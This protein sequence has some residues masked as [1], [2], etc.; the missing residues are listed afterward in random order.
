MSNILIQLLLS[1][2]VVFFDERL[3]KKVLNLLLQVTFLIFI[4][5]ISLVFYTNT[6]ESQNINLENDNFYD[7]G[8][9]KTC[10]FSINS[11]TSVF[12]TQSTYSEYGLKRDSISLFPEFGNFKCF[13]KI[14]RYETD[15]KSI[16]IFVGTSSR[17]LTLFNIL[18]GV[19]FFF[20]LFNSKHNL[21]NFVYAFLYILFDYLLN[22]Y[23]FNSS[24][25]Y[26]FLITKLIT[27]Y[28]IYEI[29]I[30]KRKLNKLLQNILIFIILYISTQ[31]FNM[32]LTPDDLYYLGYSLRGN[33]PYT[34]F[35]GNNQWFLYAS[36]IK[37]LYIV[38]GL[39]LKIFLEL[40]L[41][42]WLTGLIYFYSKH[43]KL[44][45]Q[46][47]LL[48]PV[49]ITMNQ[50]F[51]AGDQ[52]W[53]SPVPKAFFYLATLT[54]IYLLLNGKIFYANL[55]FTIA[56]YL[57]L[58][59][60]VVWLPFIAYIHLKYR[61][62]DEIVKSA[63]GVFLLSS[64]LLYFLIT[65]NF[66]NQGSENLRYDNLE[67]IIKFYMPFHVY[68]FSY[69][70]S[71]ILKINPSWYGNFRNIAIFIITVA[72]YS[73]FYNKKKTQLFSAIQFTTCVLIFYLM[74]NYISPINTFIL[75]QPYKIIS[76]LVILSVIFILKELEKLPEDSR[77]LTY[78][79][80]FIFISFS[81]FNYSL[82]E[83]GYKDTR[84][85]TSN[86]EIREKII[87]ISPEVL[88]LPLYFQGS[89][90][91]E[92]HDLEIRTEIDTYVTYHYFPQSISAIS[93]WQDR[94][95]NLEE[96]Y[97]GRCE[98]FNFIDNYIF[99]DYSENNKCGVIIEKVG[100]IF[101][102]KVKK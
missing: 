45:Q 10:E 80:I 52:F 48:F 72:I 19:V 74:V 76:L 86:E 102:Y 15:D 4:L 18:F 37:F 87:E 81:M 62:F 100:D 6:S 26:E 12:E 93:E 13:G 67:Y 99:L 22:I 69:D 51:A 59:A 98:T 96:F 36:L 101:I 91:S 88:L 46:T 84:N 32:N 73:I 42:V 92:F 56:I 65:E 55:F 29:V 89:V 47:Y 41:C 94:I 90:Q 63:I 57:H 17:L 2:L 28:L 38:F 70:A 14:T 33:T 71:N 54:A 53:G 25:N 16:L 5:L 30:K 77:F 43:F 68:P 95:L 34:S 24:L 3:S 82:S 60:F 35:F 8:N 40:L 31:P 21:F 11:F 78:L 66:I 23:I 50:S 1:K 7:I 20:L 49:L 85:F 83:I 27:M 58:A 61:K 44:S 97:L 64:P 75:L 79:S 39:S 9:F